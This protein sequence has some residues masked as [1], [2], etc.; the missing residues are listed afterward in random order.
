MRTKMT[1]QSRAH[2]LT[3]FMAPSELLKLI[4]NGEKLISTLGRSTAVLSR[5]EH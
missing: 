5:Q 1:R 2:G 4:I 3:L